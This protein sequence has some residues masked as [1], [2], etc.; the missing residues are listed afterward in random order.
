MTSE[1][2]RSPAGLS[3]VSAT[4]DALDQRSSTTRGLW[5]RGPSVCIGA[6]IKS[7]AAC[8]LEGA[9]HPRSR[10]LRV[11][12]DFDGDFPM[13]S[14]VALQRITQAELPV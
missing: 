7:A 1:H 2:E 8:H 3:S 13:T 9:I 5:M 14:L 11:P 6:G 4:R 10:Q 12:C